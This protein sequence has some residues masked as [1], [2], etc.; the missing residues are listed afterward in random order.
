MVKE[1][2]VAAVSIVTT[3]EAE[4]ENESKKTF[5]VASG[6]LPAPGA[7]FDVSAQ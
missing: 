3:V 6:K 1:P 5:V 2:T 4:P 7:P